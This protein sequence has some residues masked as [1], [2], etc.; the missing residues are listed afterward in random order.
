MTVAA[1]DTLTTARDLEAAGVERRQAVSAD[2]GELATKADLRTMIEPLATKAA[3]ILAMAAKPFGIACHK[4]PSTTRHRV[5]R[6]R[7]RQDDRAER[8]SRATGA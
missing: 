4:R 7:V 3:L 5:N 1:F 6:E 8:R 2:R